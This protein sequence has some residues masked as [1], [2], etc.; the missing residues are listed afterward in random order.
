[1]DAL[2]ICPGD[3]GDA[4]RDLQQRLAAAGASRALGDQRG[5][6]GPATTAAV[7]EFQTRRGLPASGTVD[8]ATWSAL[9]EAGHRPGDRILYLR[10]PM[11]RGDDVADLQR[12]LGAL[13]F[14]AGRV[15]GIFGPHTERALR[16][17]QRNVGLSA[18]G[19]CGPSVLA[20]LRR[21]G[22]R[23]Q[24]RMNVAG[25][26]ERET[27]RSRPPILSGRRIVLG[28][29]GGL[30]V[31]VTAIERVLK[32]GSAVVA[33]LHHPH[34]SVQ[35]VEANDFEADVYVGFNLWDQP[36]CQVSYYATT[37]FESAGGHRLADLVVEAW[38][39]LRLDVVDPCGQAVAILRETR[40][41][42]IVCQLG[43]A[44]DVV[45]RTA[46]LA[47]STQRALAEWVRAPLD[48]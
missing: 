15:D 19:K 39:D 30:D 26:R 43:P 20:S 27:L 21:L 6:Y 18:D 33:T 24:D 10:A 44:S 41:P 8:Q 25:V 5:E 42:A 35:A 13:G 17:F 34:P 40:M 29:A 12:S 47:Q 36:R 38:R 2:P 37:G 23:D 46:D 3:R 11:L 31:L 7:G 14:D 9:V 16:D 45:E 32:D 22:G 28:E 1:M 48:A 4:V